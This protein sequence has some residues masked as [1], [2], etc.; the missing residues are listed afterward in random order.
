MATRTIKMSDAVTAKLLDLAKRASGSV[1]VGFIDSDQAPIAFWNEFGHKGRFPAPPRPFFRTM[2]ANESGKWPDMMAV[3]L[4][5]NKMDSA[6]TLAFM[7]EEIDGALKQ[8]ITEGSYAPL[9]KTTL[10]LRYKFKNHPEKIRARDVLQAQADVAKGRKNLGMASDTE[11][12]PLIWTG[13]MLNSTGYQVSNGDV[14][15]LNTETEEY[16][17]R[18]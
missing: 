7:G 10:R 12:K 2:V 11:A 6:K 17:V 1:Q 14:M 3:S 18:K 5:A 4:Q 9:S 16:E 15:V 8:S 13:D